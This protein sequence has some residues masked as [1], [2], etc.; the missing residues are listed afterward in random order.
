MK[1]QIHL[2]LG[3]DG[4]AVAWEPS[5]NVQLAIT[6]QSGQ[7]KSYKLCDMMLQL[8][9]QGVHT[10]IL[11]GSGEYGPDAS[12]KPVAWPPPG[13]RFLDIS[14]PELPVGTF[15]PWAMPS[16]KMESMEQ[17]ARRAAGTLKQLFHLGGNQY[18]YL[19]KICASCL[20]DSQELSFSRIMEFLEET[21][22]LAQA[23]GECT[24]EES[25][26]LKLAI[27]LLPK[28]DVLS[29]FP[30]TNPHWFQPFTTPG[31]TVIDIQDVL[32]PYLLKTILEILLGN[33]WTQKVHSHTGCPLVLVFDECQDLNFQS[34]SNGLLAVV[35]DNQCRYSAKIRQGIVVDS[36]PLRFFGGEHPFCID[37]LRVRKDRH[38]DNDL[39][40]LTGERIHHVK[41]LSGEVHLHLLGDD[42]I[43]MQRFL[44]FLAPLGIVFTVL[45]VR[46]EL[47]LPVPAELGIPVPEHHQ[48]HILL[49]G[50]L[51]VYGFIVGHL[52]A[53]VPATGGR[54][55][56]V[57]SCSN[58]IIGDSLRKR[59]A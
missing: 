19:K 40:H 34:G 15:F 58:A 46:I 39:L 8:S 27:S 35:A 23:T 47:Q 20:A 4:E 24:P 36:D 12:G 38:K 55:L 41:G 22:Q 29:D 6:G 51:L 11:D 28:L 54:I 21:A 33:L 56:S 57:D 5:G 31:T 37:V 43:E 59:I 42:G 49:G 52:I 9:T 2:G 30:D 32:D 17:C 1:L 7:G 14:S 10:I 25:A 44:I 48:G 26:E 45:P 13:T 3:L 18:F 53:E 16:G 50:H